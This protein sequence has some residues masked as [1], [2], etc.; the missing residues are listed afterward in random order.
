MPATPPL[1]CWQQIQSFWTKMHHSLLS[2]A[3][4]LRNPTKTHL[5][6]S[7]PHS[8]RCNP[9][10]NIAIP[11]TVCSNHQSHHQC[12]HSVNQHHF[13][14]PSSTTTSLQIVLHSVPAGTRH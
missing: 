8:A 5:V 9:L 2:Q 13:P 11:D 14:L 3:Y 1:Y 12:P 7:N 6:Q 10:G 4:A